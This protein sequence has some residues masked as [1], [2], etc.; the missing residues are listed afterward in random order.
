MLD[1]YFDVLAPADARFVPTPAWTSTGKMGMNNG[2]GEET[3][4]H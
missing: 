3:H 2:Y 1:A 4:I